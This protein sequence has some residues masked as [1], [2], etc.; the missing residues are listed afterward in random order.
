MHETEPFN[1]SRKLLISGVYFEVD[2]Q[3]ELR[4]VMFLD[5]NAQS[6]LA[7]LGWQHD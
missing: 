3:V 2:F 7:I 4:S 5:H 1:L 6:L